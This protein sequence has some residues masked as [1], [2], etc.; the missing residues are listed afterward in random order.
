ML[1]DHGVL[2]AALALGE[3]APN[4]DLGGRAA[5]SSRRACGR[6]RSVRSPR[7]CIATVASSR[8]WSTRF[9]GRFAEAD[10]TVDNRTERR[11]IDGLALRRG[12]RPRYEL[13]DRRSVAFPPAETTRYDRSL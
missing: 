13:I 12:G 9:S 1:F 11:A 5:V 3:R 2:P 10:F 6:C 7:G 4:A 8:P